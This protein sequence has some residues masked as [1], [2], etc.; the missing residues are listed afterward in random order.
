MKRAEN[1]RIERLSQTR[2]LAVKSAKTK[3][4]REREREI[5]FRYSRESDSPRASTCSTCP[6][7]EDL[8]VL[9]ILL[10]PAL[11]TRARACAHYT[12]PYTK[13]TAITTYTRL[14]L[15]FTSTEKLASGNPPSLSPFVLSFSLQDRV[16][17]TCHISLIYYLLVIHFVCLFVTWRVQFTHFRS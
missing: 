2:F 17:F 6:P 4:Q 3:E 1:R 14:S 11:H 13:W 8:L 16:I 5:V 15:V 10:P 9:H 12:S 7:S